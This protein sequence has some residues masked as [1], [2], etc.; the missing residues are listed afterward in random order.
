MRPADGENNCKQFHLQDFVW[1]FC[2]DLYKGSTFCFEFVDIRHVG[3]SLPTKSTKGL[4]PAVLDT[5]MPS[6]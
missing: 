2:Q 5:V 3:S 1:L 6:L 4:A